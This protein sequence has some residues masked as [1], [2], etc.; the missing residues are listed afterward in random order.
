[1]P[2]ST[3]SGV[4]SPGVA[5]AVMVAVAVV[6]IAADQATKQWAVASL[7]PG[8]PVPLLGTFL[9][10][11]LLRNPGAAFSMGEDFTVVFTVLAMVVLA[12]LVVVALPRVRHWVWAV[13]FGLVAAG[14]GGNLVDR[15]G[16][17]PAAFH[18]HVVDFLMLP[19]F[20]V[21][22]LADSML[23]AASVLVVAMSFFGT[24]GPAGR[25]YEK[26]DDP[27]SEGPASDEEARA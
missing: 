26:A 15:L 14:V 11:Y 12:A 19:R 8:E 6:G 7:T 3:R 10:L 20:P 25:P 21:F 27:A 13:A 22:N 4:V 18:G 2:R 1:M 16:R 24:H 17:P 23:T 5:R 9:Q